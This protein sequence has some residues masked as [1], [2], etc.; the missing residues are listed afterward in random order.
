MPSS[1]SYSK[2]ATSVPGGGARDVPSRVHA[3]LQHPAEQCG[4]QLGTSGP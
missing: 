4:L 3:E 2:S 1:W